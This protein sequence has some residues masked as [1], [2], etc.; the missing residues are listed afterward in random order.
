MIEWIAVNNLVL[1]RDKTHIVEF[2]TRE[3]ENLPL[4]GYYAVR[5]G[6]FLPAFGASIS[7][8]SSIDNNY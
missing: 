4:L 5:G 2:I 3:E 7:F 8:P 1:V 6:N